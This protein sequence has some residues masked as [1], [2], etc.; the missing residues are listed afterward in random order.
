MGLKVL[1]WNANRLCPRRAQ[2]IQ[3][4]SEMSSP[5]DVICIQETWLKPSTS[6]RFDGYSCERHDRTTYGGGVM[7]LV[8]DGLSYSVEERTDKPESISVSIR[9]ECGDL[10]VTNV[11]HP[12]SY[13]GTDQDYAV[14][15]RG[16]R[17]IVLGDFNAHST[18][19]GA[20]N[21]DPMGRL[22]EGVM[23]A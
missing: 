11:Y 3:A 17:G 1:Q 9:T 2:L 15:F 13:P 8:R 18:L 12:D 20:D 16:R 19:F 14:L 23:D 4:C 21:T 22:L 5:P 7:I 6:F 10:W